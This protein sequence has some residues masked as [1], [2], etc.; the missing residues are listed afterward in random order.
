MLGTH[1][2][3]IKNMY[4][5]LYNV[6]IWLKAT[7]KSRNKCAPL[8]CY[9][10]LWP[11]KSVRWD[12][13]GVYL[14]LGLAP[15]PNICLHLQ[16]GCRLWPCRQLLAACLM[17][18]YIFSHVVNF[19]C[20]FNIRSVL[21]RCSP[22]ALH[23]QHYY[24]RKLAQLTHPCPSSLCVNPSFFTMSGR[25][26]KGLLRLPPPTIPSVHPCPGRS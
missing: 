20:G 11:I 5:V 23:E 24:P 25:L 17:I 6:N 14:V 2:R 21:H 12:L 16:H 4:N 8:T 13:E 3:I 1:M 7:G 9:A 26:T 15:C 18:K 19:L 22:K 10:K